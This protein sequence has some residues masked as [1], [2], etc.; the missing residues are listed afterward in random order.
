MKEKLEKEMAEN[1]DLLDAAG[2]EMRMRIRSV[3]GLFP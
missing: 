1:I 3:L 2:K